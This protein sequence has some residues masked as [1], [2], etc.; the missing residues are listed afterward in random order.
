MASKAIKAPKN[1]TVK[2]MEGYIKR[3]EA[4]KKKKNDKIVAKNKI[5]ALKKKAASI[6]AKK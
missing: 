3:L 5:E 2:S 1:K 4:A 6:K